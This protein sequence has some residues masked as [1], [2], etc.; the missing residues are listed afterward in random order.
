MSIELVGDTAARRRHLR[1]QALT[2]SEAWLDWSQTAGELERKVRAFNPFPIAS[3]TLN[4][5]TVR[6]WRA[7]AIGDRLHSA[8]RC[9]VWCSPPMLRAYASPVAPVSL[10][11]TELQRANGKRVTAREFR[12]RISDQRRRS[13]RESSHVATE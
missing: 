3:S 8:R 1:A 4:G 12:Q 7:Q 9:R 11:I 2:K 13:L 10:L 6:I 5:S